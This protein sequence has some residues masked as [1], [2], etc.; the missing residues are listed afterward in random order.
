MH[1]VTIKTEDL[2]VEKVEKGSR[3]LWQLVHVP[4][5]VPVGGYHQRKRDAVASL[6]Q[7]DGKVGRLP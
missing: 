2:A 3:I 6:P 1:N 5:G 4:T 7:Y